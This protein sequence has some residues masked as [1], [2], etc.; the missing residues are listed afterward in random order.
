M[1]FPYGDSKPIKPL[2]QIDLVCERQ[3]KYYLLTFQILPANVMEN[4]PGLL[5]GKDCERMGLIKVHADEVHSLQHE[6]SPPESRAVNQNEDERPIKRVFLSKRPLEK[7]DITTHYAENFSGIGYLKPPVSFTTKPEV[8]P[9]QMPIHRVPISKRAKE[10]VAIDQYV[11]AGILVKVNDPTP[12]CSNILCR[13][14]PSKFRVCMDPSQTINKSI[15]RP[16]CQMPTLNEQLHKL[17]K[18]KCFSLI[19]IKDGFLHVPLDERSSLM[20]TMHTS[21][22]RYRWTR[23]PF[24]VN[25]APEEFQNRLLSALEGLDGIAIIADDIL[26]YGTGDNY[27]EA[28]A[29][30]DANI[31]A[32]MERAIAKDLRFNP[33]KFQFKKKEIKFVGHIITADGIKADPEKVDAIINMKAPHDK[34]SL[35]RFIGMINYLSSYCENLSSVIRPLTELT[36]ENMAFIWSETQ[37]DAFNK[38]KNIIATSPVLQYFSLQKPVIL[39]VDASDNGLG[40]ALLQ[41]NGKNQLQPVAFTSCSLTSTEK[42]YSQIEKECLAI[43]N[44]FAKF[45]HWFYGHPCIE[46]HTDHKPLETIF[47]KSLNKAPAR[48][49]RMLSR[50]QR[51]QFNV[52]YKKGT[53]LHIADTLSRASLPTLSTNNMSGFDVFRVEAENEYPNRHPNLK[54]ETEVSLRIATQADDI[55]KLLYLTIQKGWPNN[56]DDLN[57]C[58]RPYWN[59]RDEL[60]INDGLIYKGHHLPCNAI[61]F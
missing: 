26:V 29:N 46:V 8:T 38:A 43:C 20:T 57:E 50:L 35:L 12:W 55:L 15:K 47:K 44:A 21:Y 13:E 18:A 34:A 30:H 39:Q 2:G 14:S 22:G 45:D 51:Y 49:Q 48:L 9:V 52:V 3:N 10:K 25:S 36:K 4:K 58:L 28:E 33:T 60:S 1:L 59:Y 11:R 37:N 6:N 53:S 16:I 61:F 56:R 41:P 27:E 32:L 40:G 24:G 5:S 17:D 19:D 7:S 31:I 42:R 54:T 23:L